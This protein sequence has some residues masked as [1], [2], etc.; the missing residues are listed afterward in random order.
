MNQETNLLIA[1]VIINTLLIIER[2]MGKMKS[3]KCCGNSEIQFKTESP[4][5][6]SSKET[7]SLSE[8]KIVNN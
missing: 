2:I 7:I 4:K 1:S 3:S 5:A 8:L 6:E